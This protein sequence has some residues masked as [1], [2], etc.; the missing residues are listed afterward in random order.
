VRRLVAQRIRRIFAILL[1]TTFPR[2]ISLFHWILASRLTISSGIEVPNAT[3]VRP[4]TRLEIP[5]F[6]ARE[7]APRTRISAQPIKIARPNMRER[8]GKI[9]LRL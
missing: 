5:N 7:E 2:T 9:I 3:I 4:I 6:F 1:Q 8:I